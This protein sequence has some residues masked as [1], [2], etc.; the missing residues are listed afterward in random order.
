MLGFAVL[1]LGATVTIRP[2]HAP[3][4]YDG[5][6]FPDEP[7]RWVTTPPGLEGAPRAPTPAAVTIGVTDGMSDGSRAFSSEQGPQIAFAVRDG[8]FTVPAGATSIEVTASPEAAPAARPANG[9][10]VSNLYRLKAIADGKPVTL[11]PNA[12]VII[13]LRA[14]QSTTQNVIISTW[15]GARWTQVATRQ[16]GQEVYAAE[17]PTLT[18]VAV[19]RLEQGVL[20]TVHA[21]GPTTR[22]SAATAIGSNPSGAVGG[23]GAVRGRALWLI[24]A[25]TIALLAAALITVRRWPEADS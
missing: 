3:P 2:P 12:T 7:Y 9:A 10:L 16:V 23:D 5:L 11:A 4:L 13:N 1:A 20:P 8:A 24:L 15:D 17:L 14:S 25:G 22:P 21:P 19:V 18:P 6:G